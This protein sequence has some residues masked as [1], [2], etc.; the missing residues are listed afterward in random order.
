MRMICSLA[1]T[2]VS[3]CC[4]HKVPHEKRQVTCDWRCVSK[5]GNTGRCVEIKE[6]R[7]SEVEALVEEINILQSRLRK[8]EASS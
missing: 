4:P 6:A 8:L 2:C 3:D 7:E 1:S 5:N